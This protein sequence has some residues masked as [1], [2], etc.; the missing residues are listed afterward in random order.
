MSFSRYFCLSGAIIMAIFSLQRVHFIVSAAFERRAR[1][2]LLG[3]RA[4]P[5]ANFLS[6][7]SHAQC[8]RGVT[9]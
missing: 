1:M 6:L 8:T 7:I 5:V 4:T 2:Q 9:N 3:E